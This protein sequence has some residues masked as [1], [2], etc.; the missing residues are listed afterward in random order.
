MRFRLNISYDGT[1]YHGWAAQNNLPTVQQTL[2]NAI[3]SIIRENIEIFCAGRT[4]A[5]VHAVGQVA[6]LDLDQNNIK[7]VLG[8]SDREIESTLLYKLNSLLPEVIVINQVLPVNA[9]FDARRSAKSRIYKYFISNDVGHR[10][11]QS[12]RFCLKEDTPLDVEKMNHEAK[13]LLGRND[14]Y[15]FIKG[16]P[17]QTTIRDLE[18][19]EFKKNLSNGYIVAT[20]QANAFAHNMVRCL[21]GASLLVGKGQ[22]D[23]GWLYQS[24]IDKKRKASLGPASAKGLFLYKVI[25]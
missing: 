16:R 13:T 9:S 20:I 25:Y 23:S 4:D 8:N 10:L 2:E 17:G 12:L 6:H 22:R 21:I 14:F 5:G 18:R 24:M 19:F 7:K 15:S 1:A 3:F 11:P